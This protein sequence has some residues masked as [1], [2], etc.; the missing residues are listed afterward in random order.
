MEITP[1]SS[2]R[3]IPLGVYHTVGFSAMCSFEVKCPCRF[4]GFSTYYGPLRIG[5]LVAALRLRRL[6]QVYIYIYIYIY[7]YI[8]IYI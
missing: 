7:M 6:R 1:G 8:Y 2:I 3:H 4:T 5:L